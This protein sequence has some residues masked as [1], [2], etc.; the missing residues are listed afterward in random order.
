MES[1]LSGRV[2]DH[3]T[4]VLSVPELSPISTSLMDIICRTVESNDAVA[5]A[6]YWVLPVRWA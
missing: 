4:K 1:L 3:L 6:R 5:K 2:T